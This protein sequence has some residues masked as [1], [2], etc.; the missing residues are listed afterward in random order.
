M[1]SS[2]D[3]QGETIN[4]GNGDNRSI[5]QIANLFDRPSVNLAPRIEPRETLA[6]ISKAKELLNWEPTQI[7]EEWIPKYKE[8]LL[9]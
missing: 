8:S 2:Q 7:I 5:N 3:G 4:I 6:D 1:H 9:K